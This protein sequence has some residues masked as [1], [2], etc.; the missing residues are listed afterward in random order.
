LPVSR[1]TQILLYCADINECRVVVA[2]R[3]CDA[4]ARCTNTPGSYIC[5]NCPAGFAGTGYTK[6]TGQ[7]IAV[8]VCAFNSFSPC[9]CRCER[10]RCQQWWLRR[11]HDVHE[12]SWIVPLLC[13]PCW[14]RRHGANRMLRSVR[15]G[16][17]P[18]SCVRAA[19]ASLELMLAADV[20]ECLANNGG[21]HPLSVCTNTPGSRSCSACP[22]GYTGNGRGASGCVGESHGSV[23]LC[24][25]CYAYARLRSWTDR[26]ECLTSNGGCSA[27]S[28]CTN[29]PGSRVCGPCAAGY[30]GNGLGTTGCIGTI[31]LRLGFPHSACFADV[32]ECLTNNGGCHPLSVCTNTAGNR[33]C[34]ACPAGFRGDGYIGCVGEWI[35]AC[36]EVLIPS[37]F[38]VC[39]Y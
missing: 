25:A 18:G 13:L 28:K 17:L 32:N 10:V 3:T 12:H 22:S 36:F 30:R 21:C 7:S 9:S 6:C 19:L 23:L 27:K 39:R 29:T 34:G 2:N 14:L 15:L 20:N 24:A 38:C 8:A 4:R 37:F 33:T 26:N 31:N 5:G 35:Y 11:S 16:F 1:R